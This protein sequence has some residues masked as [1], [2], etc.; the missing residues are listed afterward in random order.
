MMITAF[1]SGAYAQTQSINATATVNSQISIAAA[2]NLQF[3]SVTQSINKSIDK[4]NVTNA[5]RFELTGGTNSANVTLNFTTLPT[6]LADGLNLLP[7][8]F[9]ATDAGYNNTGDQGT[10]TAFNPNNGSPN[11]PLS[12]NGELWVYIGGTVA[13]GASQASGTYS[14]TITLQ[15]TY[16]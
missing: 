11:A 8:S 16:N 15:V 3:G 10:Q 5:G 1:A 13:P 9:S 7:V 4:I 12:A 14:G 6:D 2:N